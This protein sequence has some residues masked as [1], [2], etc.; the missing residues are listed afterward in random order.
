MLNVSEVTVKAVLEK[1]HQQNPEDFV[2]DF[3][4]QLKL[5]NR[6]LYQLTD[7]FLRRFLVTF[8]QMGKFADEIQEAIGDDELMQ[9]M[10]E[11]CGERMAMATSARVMAGSLVGL[12]YKCVKA[13][14]EAKELEG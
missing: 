4:A 2:D 7:D 13:E 3:L 6:E 5:E 11:R 8:G 12:V 9:S 10:V 14:V 1:A